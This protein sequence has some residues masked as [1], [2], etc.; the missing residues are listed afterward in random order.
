MLK[1]LAVIAMWYMVVGILYTD[2]P[3]WPI[4]KFVGA[5]CWAYISLDLLFNYSITEKEKR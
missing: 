5:V 4:F 1:G 3:V 2:V